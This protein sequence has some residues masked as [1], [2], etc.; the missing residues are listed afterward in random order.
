M[1]YSKCVQFTSR[2]RKWQTIWQEKQATYISLRDSSSWI[3]YKS[4]CLGSQVQLQVYSVCSVSAHARADVWSALACR[5]FLGKIY[6]PLAKSHLRLSPY[7]G[8]CV[9]S[10]TGHTQLIGSDLLTQVN[11]YNRAKSPITWSQHQVDDR[12]KPA[13]HTKDNRKLSNT[14]L[15]HNLARTSSFFFPLII[16]WAHLPKTCWAP[17]S[18][19]RHWFTFYSSAELHAV[20]SG[21]FYEINGHVCRIRS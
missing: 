1:Q 13:N 21:V 8:W 17:C 7:I 15:V 4:S 5:Y 14:W 20:S 6:T 16:L 19:K 11:I 9:G 18:M 2:L 12:A 10:C 3:S